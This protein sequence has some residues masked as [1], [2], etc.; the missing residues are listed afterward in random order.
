MQHSPPCVTMQIFMLWYVFQIITR[1]DVCLLQE[2]RDSKGKAL[3]QLLTNLNRWLN[4]CFQNTA[5]IHEHSSSHKEAQTAALTA[6]SS[7]LCVSL[8]FRYDNEHVYE[9][10]ASERLGRTESY[11]EQYVFVYRWAEL[12]VYTCVTLQLHTLK[13]SHVWSTS[14]CLGCVQDRYSDCHRPVPVP[15]W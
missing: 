6:V 1:C 2:V 8:I 7:F 3:P 5:V 15:R 14:V 10:V 13:C 12:W 9:A 4:T 11:Q